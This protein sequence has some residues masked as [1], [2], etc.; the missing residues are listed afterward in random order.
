[1]KHIRVHWLKFSFGDYIGS[2]CGKQHTRHNPQSK[3]FLRL[4]YSRAHW[5]N[6]HS[7]QGRGI[8]LL[9]SPLV[10]PSIENQDRFDDL[11]SQERPYNFSKTPLN[12]FLEPQFT[13]LSHSFSTFIP[14]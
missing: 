13:S 2:S 7:P 10:S 3:D 5:R 12:P 4:P 8:P 6:W 11:N 1:M 14:T 9:N